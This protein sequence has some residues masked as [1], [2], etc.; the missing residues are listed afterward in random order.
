MFQN[1]FNLSN[2][3]AGKRKKIIILTLLTFVALC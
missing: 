3:Q 1:L 2:G